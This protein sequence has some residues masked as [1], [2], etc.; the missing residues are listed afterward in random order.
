MIFDAQGKFSAAQAVTATAVSFNSIDLLAAG[1]PYGSS[2][3]Q[4]RA[5]GLFDIPLLIQV[6]E[7]FN[8]LTSLTFSVETDDNSAFSSA[9]T[10]A[11]TPAIPLA[12]L[13]AGYQ[14]SFDRIPRKVVERHIRLRYTVI[15]TNPTLG[16]ITAGI[17]ASVQSN[18]V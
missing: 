4:N 11:T 18:P 16:K 3:A 9:T 1:I 5:L 8:T 10:V 7:N 15:G 2:A 14:A 17:V 12:Q 6:V 13:V